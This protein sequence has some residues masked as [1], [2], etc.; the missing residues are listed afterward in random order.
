MFWNALS[1]FLGAALGVFVD[2]MWRRIE[3]IPLLR[4]HLGYF[5]QVGLGEGLNISI[6]NVGLDPLPEYMV[7]LFHAD[8]GTL[9]VF[10]P[11]DGKV[12][13]PQHPQQ[14]NTFRCLLKSEGPNKRGPEWIHMWL[15]RVN[16]KEV[17]A[18]HFAGFRLRVVLKNSEAIWFDDE[19]LGNSIAREMYERLTGKQTEQRVQYVYYKSKAPFWVEWV[20][21]YRQRKMLRNLTRVEK[22][23]RPEKTG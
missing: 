15:H 22:E 8:R 13:F 21:S 11:E 12:V 3:T 18:P 20:R 17:A 1:A 9:N 10:G 14:V 23:T 4:L 16:N 6:E 2:R 19:G 7:S 5:Q